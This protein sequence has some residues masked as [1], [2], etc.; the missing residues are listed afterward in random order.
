MEQILQAVNLGTLLGGFQAQRMEENDV[1]AASD[2]ELI[3][4]GV[5]TIG[6][7]IRLR[8]AC[9]KK[10]E[11]N[12]ASTSQSSASTSQATAAREERLSI[13]HARRHN[14]RSLTRA[15]SRNSTSNG[16][17]RSAKGSPWTPTFVC[18]ADSASS[19]APSSVDKQ[20][21]YKAGLGVKKIKLDLEDNEQTVLDKIT[22][23]TNDTLGNPLG[24][25]QLKT[26]G[27]FEMLRCTPNCRDLTEIDSCWS[28]RD[29]R[30][31]M[32]GGQGKI[33]LRPIQRSL[34]TKPLVQQSHSDVKEKCH[35][36]DQEILVRSLRDHLYTCTVGLDSNDEDGSENIT[37]TATI[38]SSTP[39]T[40]MVSGNASISSVNSD[41]LP[42]TIT[43]EA[44]D[45]IVPCF[46]QQFVTGR[47]LEV[48]SEDEVNE[49]DTNFIMVDRRNLI[50]T[51]FDEIMVLPEY[52]KTLQV[53]FYAKSDLQIRLANTKSNETGRVEIFHP[54]FGWGTVCD[55]GWD[56][57]DSRVVCRQ[58][59][60][61]GVSGTRK[62]AYYGRG[63]GS[64][65]LDDVKCT[66]NESFIWD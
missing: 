65:L 58:L 25:P 34:S 50:E 1:L 48:V 37:S 21:L 3:R 35:M 54:S 22:S 38:V 2:Q 6:D 31:T 5:S 41:G 19:K 29:L 14:S 66:G 36:C 23:D 43:A 32:G 51:A 39:S 8:E 63:T 56:D 40:S 20:I 57:T 47:A 15:A 16:S 7:R 46:Q 62:R 45:P 64:I 55:R 61:S 26:I 52:R 10:V 30:S 12:A 17:K 28:A 9:R 59:G 49:G 27:G 18:L 44:P 33:Y 4:L 13:F 11:E 24:F 60:F 53:Q 42:A